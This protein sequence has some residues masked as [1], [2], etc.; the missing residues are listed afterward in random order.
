MM[1]NGDYEKRPFLSNNVK[2]FIGE[3]MDNHMESGD[4][5]VAFQVKNNIFAIPTKD[6][7][8]IVAGGH[9][10]ICTFPPNAQNHVKCIVELDGL[11]IPIVNL[12]GAYDDLPIAGNY[13][14]IL[15]HLGQNIGI[16]ATET[17]SKAA[18]MP[19]AVLF[20]QTR[21]SIPREDSQRKYR[22][23]YLN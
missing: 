8:G 23:R 7:W 21:V 19:G 22:W 16:L 2:K 17:S 11:I 10:T 5:C 4:L 1:I 12:P 20:I 18:P 6:T 15:E 14:V 13:I 9:N 3:N